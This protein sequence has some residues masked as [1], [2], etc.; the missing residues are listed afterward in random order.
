MEKKQYP[1]DPS[2]DS[3]HIKDFGLPLQENNNE[4]NF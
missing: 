2:I 4:T 1:K 3:L